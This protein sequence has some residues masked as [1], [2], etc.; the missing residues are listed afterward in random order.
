MRN[1]FESFRSSD[2]SREQLRNTI[3]TRIREMLDADE[4]SHKGEFEGM[5]EPQYISFADLIPKDDRGNNLFSKYDVLAALGVSKDDLKRGPK[6]QETAQD[7]VREGEGIR[8]V[9][10][11]TDPGIEFIRL[12]NAVRQPDGLP[13]L[14]TYSDFVRA[15]T[16]P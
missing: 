12:I 2:S 14:T 4:H 3:T 1:F 6:S 5:R 13:T 9:W 16:R 10:P 7:W 11:T 8:L 15:T